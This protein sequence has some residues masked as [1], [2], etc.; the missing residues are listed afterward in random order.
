MKFETNPFHHQ[1]YDFST[2]P[3]VKHLTVFV[4]VPITFTW[5]SHK[6]AISM[7]IVDYLYTKMISLFLLSY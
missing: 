4:A 7:Y 2:S 1:L 6:L 3:I 5:L